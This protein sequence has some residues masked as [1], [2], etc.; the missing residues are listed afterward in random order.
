MNTHSDTAA[1]PTYRTSSFPR[2]IL[3]AHAVYLGLAAVAGFLFLDMRGLLFN[4]GP[5]SLIV[6]GAPHTMIGFVEA[7]GLAFIVAVL[8]WRAVPSRFWSLTAMATA[9]LLGV[10]NL[11]FW[12]MFLVS[13][14][15]VMGYVT[16]GLHLSFT[17]AELL[18]A[19]VPTNDERTVN[20]EGAVHAR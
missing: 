11:V 17:A 7:H 5:A 18:A 14:A 9:A 10:S 6:N 12:E 1:S 3:R 16:T 15:L 8:F 19:C 4:A 2:V 13:D 20:L